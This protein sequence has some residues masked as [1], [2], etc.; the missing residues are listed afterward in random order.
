MVNRIRKVTQVIPVLAEDCRIPVAL[1]ALRWV[2]IDSGLDNVT[3][4]IVD[5][6]YGRP[7]EKPLIQAPPDRVRKLLPSRFGLSQGATTVGAA[8]ARSLES[9]QT[10]QSF[11][12]GQ[13]LQAELGLTPEQ[14]NDAAEELA[15]HGL[16]RLRKYVGTAPFDF[17]SM[18]PT[19]ALYYKFCDY[20]AER[21]EPTQDVKQVA[22]MVV[23]HG[24]ADEGT[25][26]TTNTVELRSVVPLRVRHCQSPQGRW[27]G[28]L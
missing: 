20:L 14:I 6:A 23:S 27:N 22:A 13:A 19:Y 11:F 12:E 18:E 5:A 7:P 26:A 16:V 15:V 1:R 4:A 3:S 24:K 21:F 10:S 25:G 8:I 17:G 9:S 28:T 2:S